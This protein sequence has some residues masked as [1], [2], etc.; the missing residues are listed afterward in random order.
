MCP[1]AADWDRWRARWPTA[2]TGEIV[3]GA[4]AVEIITLDESSA[5]ARYQVCTEDG[6]IFTSRSLILAGPAYVSGKLVAG[7]DP[8]LSAA[9]GQIRYVTTGTVSLGYRLADL[10]RV[11]QRVRLR[12]ATR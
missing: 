5:G 4:K 7:L 11:A 1:Y 9:L 2:L 12:R 10:G 8:T 3:T 6:R